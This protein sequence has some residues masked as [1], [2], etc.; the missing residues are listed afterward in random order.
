MLNPQAKEYVESFLG[1][2]VRPFCTL[3]QIAGHNRARQRDKLSHLLE[4]L[5]AL[6]EEVCKFHFAKFIHFL[7][8]FFFFLIEILK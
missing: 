8:F 1:H 5:S 6:Q 2:C 7:N 3:V 4:E